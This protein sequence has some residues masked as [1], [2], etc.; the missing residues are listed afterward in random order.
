[1][2]K[3]NDCIYFLT[4]RLSRELKKVFDKKLEKYQLTSA[5]WCVLMAVFENESL[6]QKELSDI[7]CIET[8]TVTKIIDNLEKKGLII[9]APYEGDRRAYRIKSTDKAK[10]IKDDIFN[11]GNDF[12]Q[13]V[14][15]DLSPEEKD[16]VKHL[17]DKL[18]QSLQ[19]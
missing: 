12:M 15:R 7:L 3:L 2:L 9:R 5:M 19:N 16:S 17:L 8:P 11:V 18:Y 10:E 6:T 4:T 13:W 14:K 1:M